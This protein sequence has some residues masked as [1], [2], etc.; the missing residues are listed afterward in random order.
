MTSVSLRCDQLGLRALGFYAAVLLS[1]L[2]PSRACCQCLPGV[3]LGMPTSG[4]RRGSQK[5]LEPNCAVSRTSAFNRFCS[6]AQ[7]LAEN[8]R[9]YVA[10]DV[11]L[12][13]VLASGLT[14]TDEQRRKHIVNASEAEMEK[15][16]AR[17]PL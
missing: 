2:S 13:R 12:Q 3:A 5:P 4:R 1:L 8:A 9:R 15:T 17:S 14:S 7:Q 10:T 11:V 6:L 16:S